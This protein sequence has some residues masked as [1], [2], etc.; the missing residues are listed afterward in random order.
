MKHFY[1]CVIV[2]FPH[3]LLFLFDIFNLPVN[4]GKPVFLQKFIGLAE[5]PA[6]EKILLTQ[7]AGLDVQL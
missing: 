4:G 1:K 7:T 3:F 6:S 2:L 5:M